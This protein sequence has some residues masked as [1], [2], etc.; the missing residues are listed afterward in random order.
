MRSNIRKSCSKSIVPDNF[1][2]RKGGGPSHIS[3]D[4]WLPH[5]GFP[6]VRPLDWCNCPDYSSSTGLC[7]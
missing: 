3:L 4:G 7:I 5:V 1:G 6:V 2:L